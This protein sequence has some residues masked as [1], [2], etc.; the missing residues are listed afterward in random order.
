MIEIQD[1]SL[2]GPALNAMVGG[3]GGYGFPVFDATR[4]TLFRG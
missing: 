2:S 4:T 1:L 3:R